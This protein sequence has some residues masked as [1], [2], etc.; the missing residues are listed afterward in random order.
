MSS[1][2]LSPNFLA[3]GKKIESL[4]VDILWWSREDA[5][6][7]IEIYRNN[8]EAV[9]CCDAVEKNNN[10]YIYNYHALNLHQKKEE[11]WEQF[12]VRSCHEAREYVQ[13]IPNHSPVYFAVI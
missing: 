4:S 2:I 9:A 6:S 5:L 11:T 10:Q 1:F 13:N 7:L 3:K 12:V 8:Q